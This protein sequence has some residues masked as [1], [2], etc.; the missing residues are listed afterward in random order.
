MN[1]YS[2]ITVPISNKQK[3]VNLTMNQKQIY[4]DLIF[5]RYQGEYAKDNTNINHEILSEHLQDRFQLDFYPGDWQ[6]QTENQDLFLTNNQQIDNDFI[7][8]QSNPNDINPAHIKVINS[9]IKLP[10]L[11]NGSLS[12]QTIYTV[13]SPAQTT[14]HP[15]TNRARLERILQAV[16]QLVNYTPMIQQINRMYQQTVIKQIIILDVGLSTA[17]LTAK[18]L[19]YL[20]TNF[21]EY[22][23]VNTDQLFVTNSRAEI[24][25][26]NLAINPF[27]NNEHKL[28]AKSFADILNST[29]WNEA[30]S[31]AVNG[32]NFDLTQIGYQKVS[33]QKD[34][35]KV[36]W[37][38]KPTEL[39]DQPVATTSNS[40]LKKEVKQIKKI[41]PLTNKPNKESNKPISAKVDDRDRLYPGDNKDLMDY[42]NSRSVDDVIRSHMIH[43]RTWSNEVTVTHIKK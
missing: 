24:G 41:K 11:S 13:I 27:E 15:H 17:P 38:T 37:L 29:E 40:P 3:E 28:S 36:Q 9:K 12:P 39:K 32:L 26:Q 35:S 33:Y 25:A 6:V 16:H 5:N 20:K 19:S 31:K 42:A 18:G 34:Q 14:M 8:Q 2:L 43:D 4:D 10:I 23:D 7:E 22:Y 1:S 21:R 30:K